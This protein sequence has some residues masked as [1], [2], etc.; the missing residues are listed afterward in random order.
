MKGPGEVNRGPSLSSPSGGSSE[1]GT[2]RTALTSHERYIDRCRAARF[3]ATC[4]GNT[5][6]SRAASARIRCAARSLDQCCI[7]VAPGASDP[8]GSRP[9][10]LFRWSASCDCS[11]GVSNGSAS[12]ATPNFRTASSVLSIPTLMGIWYHFAILFEALFILT[13]VDAGTRVLSTL[14]IRS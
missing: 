13:T 6:A 1:A 2:S 3:P 5:T 9:R 10:F 12:R 7:S 4:D 8:G 11:C 14:P